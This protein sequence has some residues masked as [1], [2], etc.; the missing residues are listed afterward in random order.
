MVEYIQRQELGWQPKEWWGVKGNKE[1]S[2]EGKVGTHSCAAV[3]SYIT[4]KAN[5]HLKD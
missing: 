2:E 1:W 3:S 4:T 5:K